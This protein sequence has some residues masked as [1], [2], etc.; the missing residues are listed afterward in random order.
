VTLI[1]SPMATE[2]PALPASSSSSLDELDVTCPMEV[3]FRSGRV[4]VFGGLQV[5]G[6][7]LVCWGDDGSGAYT[8]TFTITA[9]A[10]HRT[11][12]SSL[13][14]LSTCVMQDIAGV[15]SD[16]VGPVVGGASITSPAACVSI[17][18]KFERGDVTPV[19]AYS[20]TFHLSPELAACGARATEG[21]YLSSVSNTQFFLTDNGGGSYTADCSILGPVCGATGSGTLFS[22]QL[23]AAAGVSSGTG[24]VVVDAV[25][26]RSCSNGPV[27]GDP[28][29]NG[30]V[31][32]QT[33][34][35]ASIQSLTATQVKTG[36]PVPSSTTGIQLSW[37]P[38]APGL[39]VSVVRKG[40]GNYPF[41]QRG[42]SPGSAPSPPA[43]LADALSHGWDGLACQGGQCSASCS[44]GS[45]ASTGMLDATASRDFLYYDVFARD[46]FGNASAPSNMTPGTLSYD[47]GD[48]SD[49]STTCS[50]D[51][52]VDMADI[53]LLG[54]HY[55]ASVASS[56]SYA[57]LDVGPTTDYSVDARPA[58]DGRVSFE[59]LVVMAINFSVV[60]APQFA[61]RPAPF[62][63][64]AASLALPAT[65][66]AVGQTFDAAV[67][68]DGAGDAQAV[69]VRLAYDAAVLEQVGVAGG[70]LLDAQGR[71]S[72]VLSSGPGDVDAALLGAGPG[73]AGHGPVARVTFRVKAPGDGQLAIAGVSARDVRNRPV[74]VAGVDAGAVADARTGLGLV[75]PNPFRDAVEIRMS[76]RRDGAANLAVYDVAG[77]RVRTLL[78]GLQP[79][80]ARTVA[81][82]GCDDA[83]LK[84][85][86]GAYV[87]RLEAADRRESRTLRLVR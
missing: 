77:R 85:A 84:L 44:S 20:V 65:L 62:A 50:G 58:P 14:S 83:G 3:S 12:P 87:V 23:G 61:A 81:W 67:M 79:A 75:F 45:C 18:F 64:D 15:A 2:R 41:Y 51:D 11:C 53:S 71:P 63:T 46:V 10:D 82:D 5:A 6:D 17:P 29:P 4:F 52:H 1:K 32:I 78:H 37:S 16:V 28:G 80:G 76:L 47:L 74:A 69:S 42:S 73:I 39:S 66:P 57:C 36:N 21:S 38:P 72:A 60:S 9:S 86:P 31:P 40:F 34:A 30:Y 49:G 27:P 55:G 22:L 68:L 8:G 70:T 48:V 26:V 35:P 56:S 33:T 59:D 25:T 7:Q 43:S 54:A 13:S 24:V 19:R